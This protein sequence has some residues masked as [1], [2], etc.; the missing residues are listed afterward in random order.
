ML[1]P[2]RP[3]FKPTA[4]GSSRRKR[5]IPRWLVL[6][7]TGI[8]LGAGGLL[9]L[10]TSY[11]PTR[12]TAEQSEQLHF[13][14]NSANS[15]KQRLQ[16]DLTQTARQFE[17]T[18][19]SNTALSTEVNQ[20]KAELSKLKADLALFADAMPPDPRGTSPGIRAGTFL[21]DNGELTYSILLM[22]DKGKTDTFKGKMEFVAAGRFSNGRSGNID[23][24]P[25]EQF[26]LGRYEYVEGQIELPAGFTPR[27]ITIR[28]KPIDSERVVATRTLV[29]NR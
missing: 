11:G 17:D 2:K 22:Q 10:Q 7:L 28:I 3:A 14:L 1:G 23:L 25:V 21:S 29:V 5:R 12:L 27:Q 18:Q 16:A 24:P 13:D 8:A 6:M 4:Y 15:D 9:F 19:N 20:L 26:S